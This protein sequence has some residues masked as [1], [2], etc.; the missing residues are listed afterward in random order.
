[1]DYLSQ[2]NI[3]FSGLTE[4]TYFYDFS[5]NKLF[6][7]KLEYT[8]LNDAEIHVAVEMEKQQGMLVFVFSID[9]NLNLT[10]DRCLESFDFPISSTNEFYVKFGKESYEESE[11]VFVISAS[12]H[13]IN[14]AQYIYEY[15]LLCIPAKV[16][17]PDNEKGES[18]C[19]PEFL[20]MLKNFEPEK[21]SDIDPRW[22]SLMKLKDNKN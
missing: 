21:K 5:V 1:M 18:T 11:N 2:F 16:V 17:H 22:E 8:E 13:Q 10:C 7:E 19:N 15:I 14:I 4:D 6:F 12:E 20:K 9:G 3:E